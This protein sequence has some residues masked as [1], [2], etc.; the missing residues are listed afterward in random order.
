MRPPDVH[1]DRLL[2]AVEGYY[3][4]KLQTHGPTPAGVDWNSSDSQRSRF[5]Q[6]MRIMEVL[7]AIPRSINDFGCGYGALVDYIDTSAGMSYAGYDISKKMIDEARRIYGENKDR[8]FT[9]SLSEVPVSDV[10][11][12]SGIFNVRLDASDEAWTAHVWQTVSTIRSRTSSG[13][14]MNF[15]S[16]TRSDPHRRRADLY[17]ADPE[18]VAQECVRRFGGDAHVLEDYGLWEFTLLVNLTPAADHVKEHE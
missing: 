15:L 4:A 16:L 8:Y 7:S 11:V 6:L 18:A 12:A 5:A 14:A 17:Y 1:P 13:M 2:A 9:S 3:S 10:S